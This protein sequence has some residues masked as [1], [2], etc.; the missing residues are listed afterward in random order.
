MNNQITLKNKKDAFPTSSIILALYLVL[1]FVFTIGINILNHHQTFSGMMSNIFSGLL[2]LIIPSI[3]ILAII[4]LPFLKVRGPLLAIP[5][6]ALAL[7]EIVC[8][9]TPTINLFRFFTYEIGFYI[10]MLITFALL[11]I[12]YILMGFAAI[13]STN[14]SKPIWATLAS[15]LLLIKALIAPITEFIAVFCLYLFGFSVGFSYAFEGAID[16]CL[17]NIVT[18]VLLLILGVIFAVGM[19]FLGLW[20]AKGKQEIAVEEVSETVVENTNE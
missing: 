2:S 11:I 8:L 16:S 19:F 7:W 17:G 18:T 12:A 13:K 5:F 15:A 10:S 4:V 6:A 20:M 14:A 1:N 3:I 9:I